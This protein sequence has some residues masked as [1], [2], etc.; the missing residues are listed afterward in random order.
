MTSCIPFQ[1]S[2]A[3]N[4]L[5][6]LDSSHLRTPEKP[7]RRTARTKPLHGY[8]VYS[9]TRFQTKNGVSRRWHAMSLKENPALHPSALPLL[10]SRAMS[11]IAPHPDVLY[12]HFSPTVYKPWG[13]PH[14]Q[15]TLNKAA[16]WRGTVL[17]YLLQ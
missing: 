17:T 2:Q 3:S 8:Q 14:L 5:K 15:N 11:G 4:V 6:T 10:S 12:K 9:A 1:G 16:N 13:L 7:A